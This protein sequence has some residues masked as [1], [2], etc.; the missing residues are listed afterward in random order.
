MAS[1]I[2]IKNEALAELPASRITAEDEA[3]VEA[4]ETA[5]A[6]DDCKRD[7]LESHPWSF[8]TRRAV[9]AE[10]TNPRSSEWL[11]AYAV[12]SDMASP[13]YLI[14][15]LSALGLGLPIPGSSIP[16]YYEVWSGL[17]FGAYPIFILENGVIYSNIETA[18]LEYGVN[19]INESV[20]PGLF[21]RALALEIASRIV[22]PIK[23]DRQLKGDL[24]K[25]AEAQKSRA[26]AEDDNRHPK[27]FPNLGYMNEVGLARSGYGSA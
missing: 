6:Y 12:P 17:N 16:P 27:A 23:K 3:S 26:M 13:R 20:M 5:A 15:D 21:R 8:A 18:T 25:Q 19:N 22:M 14:P 9:L 10:V 7:L 1:R 24:I 11:F 2:G 4:R